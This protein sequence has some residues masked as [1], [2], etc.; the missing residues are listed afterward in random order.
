MMVTSSARYLLSHL[1]VHPVQSVVEKLDGSYKNGYRTFH[2]TP[3]LSLGDA[4]YL[5]GQ[6]DTKCEGA[7]MKYI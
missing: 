3:R 6:R 4:H 7:V 5:D 2:K 1:R